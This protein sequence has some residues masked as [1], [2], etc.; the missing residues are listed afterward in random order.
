[1]LRIEKLTKEVLADNL[2][3]LLDIEERIFEMANG[4]YPILWTE[5]DFL[6][7]LPGKWTY[8]RVIVDDGAIKGFTTVSQKFT[9]DG[10]A[11]IHAHKIA[12]LA[13]IRTPNLILDVWNDTFNEARGEG[14][15]WFTASIM[16]YAHPAMLP[17]YLRVLGANVLKPKEKIEYFFGKLPDG[18]A[19]TEDGWIEYPSGL[20]KHL[21]LKDFRVDHSF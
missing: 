7:E 9:G 1:M 20:R 19:V 6:R 15:R 5:K 13:E 4:T 2:R 14:L 11:F 3:V 17:W 21:I 12:V 10:E 16:D 18:T 8:S